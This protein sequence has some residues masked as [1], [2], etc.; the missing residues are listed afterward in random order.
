MVKEKLVLLMHAGLHVLCTHSCMDERQCVHLICPIMA[1]DES[2]N[3][4]GLPSNHS[5]ASTIPSGK[6]PSAA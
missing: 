3:S 2:M 6:A 5:N 1:G 4:L